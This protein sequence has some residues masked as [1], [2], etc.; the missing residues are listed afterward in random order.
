VKKLGC[1]IHGWLEVRGKRSWK[2]IKTIPTNRDYDMFGILANTRNYVNAVPISDPR[3]LPED[4]SIKVKKESN[5]WGAGGHSHSW[6]S[7]EDIKNYDWTQVFHDGRISEVDI[8]T[9]KEISKSTYTSLQDHPE[10]AEKHGVKL[11]YRTRIAKDLIKQCWNDCFAEMAKLSET[12]GT[13]NVRIVFW[14][15]N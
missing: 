13:R 5:D 11:E 15:D 8:K 6:L 2:A 10:E 4:V 12:Y 3:G 1:D 9:G 7:Y 14:F